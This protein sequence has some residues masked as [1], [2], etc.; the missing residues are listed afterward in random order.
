MAGIFIVVDYLWLMIADTD[1][2][3]FVTSVITISHEFIYWDGYAVKQPFEIA[4]LLPEP[5]DQR[6][7]GYTKDFIASY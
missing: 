2:R 7:R 5:D 3:F 6:K 4:F 1:E